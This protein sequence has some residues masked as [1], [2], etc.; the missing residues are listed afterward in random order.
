[1]HCWRH[2]FAT[3]QDDSLLV[4]VLCSC[5]YDVSA[6]EAIHSDEESG[7]DILSATIK[8]KEELKE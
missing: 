4:F 8:A 1:M 3:L 2:C 5:A 6:S 7:E